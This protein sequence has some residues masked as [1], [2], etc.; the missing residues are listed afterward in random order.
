[1]RLKPCCRFKPGYGG[2]DRYK[3]IRLDTKCFD[4]I[5]KY[6]TEKYIILV[7]KKT[8][9]NQLRLHSKDTIDIKQLFQES[10][11]FDLKSINYNNRWYLNKTLT[12]L[13]DKRQTI[14]IEKESGE[15][16]E[17]I[18]RRKYNYLKGP[19]SGRGGLEYIDLKRNYVIIGLTYW[20]S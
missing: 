6:E 2:F 7:D 11:T 1:M 9:L 10:D 17:I 4:N 3:S 18:N 16:V 13:I 19:R 20:I 12:K 5:A 14:I 15:R 8:A